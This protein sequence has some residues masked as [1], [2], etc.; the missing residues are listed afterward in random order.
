ML[1]VA[2]EVTTDK[3]SVECPAPE[4]SPAKAQSMS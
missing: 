1:N 2:D 4:L 3:N